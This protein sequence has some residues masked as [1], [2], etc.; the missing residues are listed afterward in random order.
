MTIYILMTWFVGR[1]MHNGNGGKN[2]KK[3]NKNTK[4]AAKKYILQQI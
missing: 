4:S 1:V 3:V 2:T